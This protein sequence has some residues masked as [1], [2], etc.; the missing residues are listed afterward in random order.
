MRSA[1]CGV[2]NSELWWA[3]VPASRNP[4][5]VTFIR[6]D[7]GER[8]FQFHRRLTFKPHDLAQFASEATASNSRPMLEVGGEFNL[9]RN[10]PSSTRPIQTGVK[11]R[12]GGKCF[13]SNAASPNIS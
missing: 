1:E 8:K 11:S 7:S 3:S 12:N 6:L 5:F 9:R 2:R 4:H 10:I 13:I